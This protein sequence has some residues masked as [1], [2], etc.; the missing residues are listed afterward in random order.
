MTVTPAY[1]QQVDGRR[2]SVFDGLLADFGVELGAFAFEILGFGLAGTGAKDG[3]GSFG[4][5]LLP[6]GNLHRMD[7][8]I[9]G[10]LLDC[11][12]ASERFKRHAS[13]EFGVVSSSFAFH[14]VC[15]RLYVYV[16]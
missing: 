16:V 10:D 11:F 9:L 3:R 15:V 6:L 13:L 5:R 8:E 1:T 12:D 7:V 14:F 4:H 2:I